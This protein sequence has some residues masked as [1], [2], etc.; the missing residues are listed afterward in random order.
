AADAVHRGE[1][2]VAACGAAI[3]R[4]GPPRDFAGNIVAA[5]DPQMT[6]FV[7]PL[8]ICSGLMGALVGSRPHFRDTRVIV[9]RPPPGSGVCGLMAPRRVWLWALGFGIWLPLYGVL[10]EHNYSM[11]IVLAFP[12]IGAYS[13]LAVNKLISR[14]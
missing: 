3:G 7:L 5:S 11:I 10:V 6:R 9:G 13:G 8:A 12:F 14:A 4:L 1:D 2:P